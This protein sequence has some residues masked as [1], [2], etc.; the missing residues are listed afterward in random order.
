MERGGRIRR[1]KLLNHERVAVF[2]HCDNIIRPT[3]QQLGLGLSYLYNRFVSAGRPLST[4]L[5]RYIISNRNT[6]NYRCYNYHKF[7]GSPQ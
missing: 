6:A 3:I 2:C 4:V 7:L 5:P 1:F